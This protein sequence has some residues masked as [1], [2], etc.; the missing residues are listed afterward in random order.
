M[1]RASLGVGGGGRRSRSQSRGS[2]TPRQPPRTPSADAEPVIKGQQYST[3]SS[4]SDGMDAQ[5]A[6]Y[7]SIDEGVYDQGLS[8]HQKTFSFFSFF[9]AGSESINFYIR[10][11]RVRNDERAHQSL[12]FSCCW[13]VKKKRIQAE[14]T[15]VTGGFQNNSHLFDAWVPLML[16]WPRQQSVRAGPLYYHDYKR[17]TVGLIYPVGLQ[18][19]DTAW[20]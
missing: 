9:L 13:F 20:T 4:S 14:P 1:D 16:F 15:C 6:L 5:S 17:A 7:E 10:H 2:M 8:T 11:G 18:D 12:D 3:Q 19:I